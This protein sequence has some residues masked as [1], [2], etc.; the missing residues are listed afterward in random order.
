MLQGVA[1]FKLIER[2]AAKV[3]EFKDVRARAEAL[4]QRQ[5]SEQAWRSLL[6]DLR[7]QH[8]V[9]ILDKAISNKKIWDDASATKL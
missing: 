5:H 8:K 7:Q 9:E 4:L 1:L 2:R 6:V 3:N